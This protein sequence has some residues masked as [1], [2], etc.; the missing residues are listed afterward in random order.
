MAARGGT[1]AGVVL[2]LG[3]PCAQQLAVTLRLADGSLR[4]VT[5]QCRFVVEPAGIA[6]VQPGGVVLPSGRRSRPSSG[7]SSGSRPPRSRSASSMPAVARPAS[8]RTDVVPLLSKAGCNMGACH[9]NLNGKG[10][11]RLSLRGDDPAFDYQVADPRPVRPA[12]EPDRA[13]ASLIVLKPTGARRPRRGHAVQLATRSRPRPCS[14]GSLRVPAT[15]GPSAPRVKSLRV[16]PAERILAPGALDQQLVVT[17]E[18]DDGTTRDVTRQ[19]AYDVSD[20]TRVEVSVDGLVH[21]RGRARRR[22]PFAT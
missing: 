5:A 1:V 2:V 15:I 20:P 17:A 22:S 7:R 16:F 14:P 4:D 9:G 8:F 6:I 10:G 21:A 19:A 12:A 11:F 3:W 13:G 18:F